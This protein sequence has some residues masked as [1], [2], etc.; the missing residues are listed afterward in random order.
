MNRTMRQ[1]IYS[2]IAL[3]ALMLVSCNK[4][5]R[6]G[7]EVPSD[8]THPVTIHADYVGTKTAYAEDQYFSWIKG[9]WIR[10]QEE[11]DGVIQF[12]LFSAASTGKSSEFSGEITD[13]AVLGQ[14]A[15][16]PA[17]LQPA[18]NDGVLSVT[19]P[20]ILFPDPLEPGDNLPLIGQKQEDGSYAF[21]SSMGLV[22]F[23]LT[24]VPES[25][26]RLKIIANN[27]KINGPFPVEAD[28]SIRM[29]ASSGD[30]HINQ[31][32]D[33]FQIYPEVIIDGTLVVYV[34]VPVGTL[35]AGLTIQLTT[36]TNGNTVLF[37]KTTTKDIVIPRNKVTSIA[38]LAVPAPGEDALTVEDILGTYTVTA[39]TKYDEDDK[40]LDPPVSHELTLTLVESDNP[41]NGNVMFQGSYFGFP[42]YDG[43]VYA[44]FNETTN[45]LLL[46]N[47]TFK[48]DEE[49]ELESWAFKKAANGNIYYYPDSHVILLFDTKDKFTQTSEF[50]LGIFNLNTYGITYFEEISGTRNP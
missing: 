4:E 17:T 46:Q 49:T 28:G 23:T 47:N 19:L 21:V 44:V 9:D 22:K 14:W 1:Y 26:S 37:S 42:I 38:P 40:P 36:G 45:E 34:P 31:Q 48:R 24:N 16:Y 11:K 18:V 2:A 5:Q 41:T 20:E 29:A 25:A 50:F 15:V 10:V 12:D 13:G 3:A 30:I 33:V 8:G 43:K 6:P 27:Q 39:V 7:V 32:T 35:N